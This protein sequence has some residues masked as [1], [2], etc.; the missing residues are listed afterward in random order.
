MSETVSDCQA[1]VLSPRFRLGDGKL[2]WPTVYSIHN[3]ASFFF[4]RLE[5][6]RWAVVE[7]LARSLAMAWPA[8]C[9]CRGFG[10]FLSGSHDYYGEGSSTVL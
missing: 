10:F 4:F 8:V 5:T 2:G 6:S 3:S 7:T 1:P 9:M